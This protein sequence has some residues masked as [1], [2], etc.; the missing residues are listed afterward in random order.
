MGHVLLMLSVSQVCQ[1]LHLC[2][3]GRLQHEQG[4]AHLSKQQ[5]VI[6]VQSSSTWVIALPKSSFQGDCVALQ[7]DG[8]QVVLKVGVKEG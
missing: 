2:G 8:D 5:F 1:H 3:W 4:G 7:F 6:W